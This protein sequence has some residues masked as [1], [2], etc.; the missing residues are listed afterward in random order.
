LRIA[1]SGLQIAAQE[2][3][4]GGDEAGQHVP[5]GLVGL[6]LPNAVALAQI[7]NTNGDVSHERLP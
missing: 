6:P 2:A 7:L 5:Q 1:D 3:E 4:G